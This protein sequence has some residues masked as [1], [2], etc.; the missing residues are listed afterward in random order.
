MDVDQL[1][2][3]IPCHVNNVLVNPASPQEYEQLTPQ[4]VVPVVQQPP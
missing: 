3:E 4:E 2:V 1:I